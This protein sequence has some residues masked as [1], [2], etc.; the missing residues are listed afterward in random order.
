[1]NIHIVFKGSLRGKKLFQ[2]K[3]KKK[4]KKKL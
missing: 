3:K 1:M 4:K 2:K